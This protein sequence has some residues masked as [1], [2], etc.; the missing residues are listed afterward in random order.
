MASTPASV[1]R[2]SQRQPTACSGKRHPI[3]I[4]SQASHNDRLLKNVSEE[5]SSATSRFH[6]RDVPDSINGVYVRWCASVRRSRSIGA[7]CSSCVNSTQISSSARINPNA[8][9]LDLDRRITGLEHGRRPVDGCWPADTSPADF[10]HASESIPSE[11]VY[12]AT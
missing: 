6:V 11:T 4:Q 7:N 5:K 8:V 2:V 10:N 1:L 3:S 9:L 12:P